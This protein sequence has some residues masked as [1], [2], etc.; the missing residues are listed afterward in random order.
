MTAAQ[1]PARVFTNT[2][3]VPRFPLAVPTEVTVL[4][5]GIPYSI[6]GRSVTLGERGLGLVLAGEL[7]PGDSVGIEFRLPDAGGPFRLKAIVR[8]QAL[9]HCG[10]EFVSL[11]SE[12]QTLIEHWVRK[13]TV[14]NPSA[15]FPAA[16]IKSSAP[17]WA[18]TAARTAAV[19][20]KR[21][22]VFWRLAASVAFGLTLLAGGFGWWYWH[23]AWGE[24]EAH[25]P[26]ARE[27]SAGGMPVDVPAEIMEKLVTHKVQPIYPE[28]ARRARVQGV[29]VLDTTISRDG[30]VLNIRP[31][32]GPDE[33]T[34]AAVDAVKW[35]H[36]QPYLVNGQAVQVRTTLAVDFHG[37]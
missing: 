18:A 33:L 1:P 2:R 29:V 28:A 37:N 27:P 30:E 20:K 17:L 5:S 3:R 34:P 15:T 31:V 23:Q 25:I 36:F 13:K 19:R 22:R 9:L 14:T 6:P 16:G 11:T 35:W 8:Y 7:N 21:R 32:S 12:Q 24:L 10:L 4:R 26:P